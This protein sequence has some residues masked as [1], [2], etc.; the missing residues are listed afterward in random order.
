M[1]RCTSSIMASV[2]TNGRDA[3]NPGK[4][5]GYLL[6]SSAI[7]SFAICINSTAYLGSAE[8]SIGGEDSDRIWQYSSKPSM[9]RKRSPRSVIIGTCLTRLC[10]F[11]GFGDTSLSLLKKP[12]G[13]MW[14]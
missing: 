12:I 9:T 7:S 11:V 4:R 8:T 6:H 2:L 1:L 13:M 3:M 10:I 14:L 5:S